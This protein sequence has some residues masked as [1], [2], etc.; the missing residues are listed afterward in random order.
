MPPSLKRLDHEEPITGAMAG[1]FIV[2]APG[3]ARSHGL[4]LTA[5]GQPLTRALIK[6]DPWP[7]GIVRFL[8]QSAPVFPPGDELGVRRGE[9]P[10]LL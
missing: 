5:L 10:L 4:G 8:V 7:R 9:A 3:V 1:V 2:K 6:A